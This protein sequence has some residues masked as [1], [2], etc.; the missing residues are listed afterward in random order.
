M[1][2]PG[3]RRRRGEQGRT[4]GFGGM[5][6]NKLK[7]RFLASAAF[8]TVY[9][10]AY[11]ELYAEIYAR[12]GAKNALDSIAKVLPTV[13]GY[14]A[15]TTTADVEALRTLI[16]QRTEHLATDSVITSG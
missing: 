10:D 3:G 14:D 5:G 12:N 16:Q 15:Q 1:Q 4:R 6:G 2:P 7:E 11:R 13:D 8:K 9:E